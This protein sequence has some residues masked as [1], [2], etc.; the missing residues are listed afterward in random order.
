MN[1]LQNSKNIQTIILKSPLKM[2]K[3][4]LLFGEMVQA[5]VMVQNNY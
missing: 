3:S 4:W 2:S 5:E 1:K